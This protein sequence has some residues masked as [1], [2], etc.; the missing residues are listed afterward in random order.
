MDPPEF[1]NMTFISIFCFFVAKKDL[2]IYHKHK[3]SEALPKRSLIWQYNSAGGYIF[4][5]ELY[6]IL[7]KLI[8]SN[9]YSFP[10]IV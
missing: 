7:C 1:E 9:H 5:K 4:E 10:S 2:K 6:H 8:I 3:A